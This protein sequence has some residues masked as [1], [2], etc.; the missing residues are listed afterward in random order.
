M[1]SVQVPVPSGLPPIGQTP[2]QMPPAPSLG[3]AQVACEQSGSGMQ[4]WPQMD[5]RVPQ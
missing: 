5:V 4:D 3:F 2:G 1:S